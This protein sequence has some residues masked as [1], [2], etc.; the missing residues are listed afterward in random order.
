MNA[1]K[2][3]LK[4]EMIKEGLSVEELQKLLSDN[5]YSYTVASINSKISRGSF[6]ANFLLQ[7]LEVMGRTNI[8]LENLKLNEIK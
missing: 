1:A 2:K 4:I 3:I 8:S 6:S 7:C 5:G